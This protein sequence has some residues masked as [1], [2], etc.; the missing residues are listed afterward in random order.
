MIAIC[1]MAVHPKS[2]T[3][4]WENC[5]HHELCLLCKDK[6]PIT[7]QKEYLE[8]RNKSKNFVKYKMF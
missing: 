8:S 5:V 1:E 6:K 4:K 2:R 7:L 3:E